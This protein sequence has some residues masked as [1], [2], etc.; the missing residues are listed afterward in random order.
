[1][2]SRYNPGEAAI[3]ATLYGWFFNGNPTAVDENSRQSEFDYKR[4]RDGS[5]AVGSAD[6]RLCDRVKRRSILLPSSKLK[7]K[8]YLIR[9]KKQLR[10]QDEIYNNIQ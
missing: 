2:K 10:G 7:F 3:K 9:S 6:E 5:I 8:I 4:K 1:L